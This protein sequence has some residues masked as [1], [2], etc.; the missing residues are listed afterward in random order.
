MTRYDTPRR[1]Y[2]PALWSRLPCLLAGHAWRLAGRD[3]LHML[4]RCERRGQRWHERM[5]VTR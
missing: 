4:W 3:A 5:E 1:R 2:L